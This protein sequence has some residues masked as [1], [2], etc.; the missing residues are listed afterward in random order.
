MR[1]SRTVLTALAGLAIVSLHRDLWADQ[2]IDPDFF[3]RI[4]DLR[5]SAKVSEA[6]SLVDAKI[7]ESPDNPSLLA[8]EADLYL[9]SKNYALAEELCHKALLKSSG[10]DWPIIILAKIQIQKNRPKL[11]LKLIDEVPAEKRGSE[12]HFL[13][14]RILVLQGEEIQAENEYELVLT[15]DPKNS[16]AYDRLFE[17]LQKKPD[18]SRLQK[19]A[20]QAASA[21]VPNAGLLAFAADQ[22]LLRGDFDQAEKFSRQ[23]LQLAPTYDWPLFTLVKVR[24][25]Q[26]RFPEALVTLD[27]IQKKDQTAGYHLL[28]AEAL[29]AQRKNAEADAEYSAAAALDPGNASIQ[30]SRAAN[31]RLYR[32]PSETLR[33]VDALLESGIRS[34]GLLSIQVELLMSAGETKKALKAARSAVA[35]N[36]KFEWAVLLEAKVFYQAGKPAESLQALGKISSPELAGE[37]H[38]L[39]AKILHDKRRF[40][41]ADREF[42]RALEA[43]FP[44]GIAPLGFFAGKSENLRSAGM[45]DKAIQT[46]DEGLRHYPDD[47]PL[48]LAKAELLVGTKRYPEAISA[49][50]AL[51]RAN[52]QLERASFLIAVAL[53]RMGRNA[54]ALNALFSVTNPSWEI[55]SLKG[56]IFNE[57]NRLPEAQGNYARAVSLAP[58]RP[59]LYVALAGVSRKQGNALEARKVIETAF[60]R[61]LTSAELYAM[62]ADFFFEDKKYDQAEAAAG[63]ALALNPDLGWAQLILSKA[64]TMSGHPLVAQKAIERLVSVSHPT[65]EGFMMQADALREMGFYSEADL[66]YAKAIRLRGKVPEFHE[67]RAWNGYLAGNYGLYE[68]EMLIA[69]KLDPKN[70]KYPATLANYYK[71]QRRY[72]NAE[73]MLSSGLDTC[74]SNGNCSSFYSV[75]QKDFYAYTGKS[76]YE[77][78]VGDWAWGAAFYD[79]FGTVRSDIEGIMSAML[80]QNA[81]IGAASADIPV[82]RTARNELGARLRVFPSGDS[83]VF[84]L[85]SRYDQ[86]FDPQD[87]F[88]EHKSVLARAEYEKTF[89]SDAGKAYTLAPYFQYRQFNGD[90]YSFANGPSTFFSYETYELGS[91]LLLPSIRNVLQADFEFGHTFGV[92]SQNRFQAGVSV[93]VSDASTLRFEAGATFSDD[94][95]SAEN[96]LRLQNRISYQT[97]L[98]EDVQIGPEVVLIHRTDRVAQGPMTS[99]SMVLPGVSANERLSDSLWLSQHATY[100]RPSALSEYQYMSLNPEIRY[101]MRKAFAREVHEHALP[102]EIPIEFT[103]GFNAD[104]FPEMA[105][106]ENRWRYEVYGKVSFFW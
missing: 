19:L 21:H 71:N 15:S 13:R 28:R 86:A 67:A 33:F 61:K 1:G 39:R 35:L 96:T 20:L 49:I 23:A 50:Q 18:P 32:P 44:G 34:A 22:E 55:F 41:E 89:V 85:S 53:H 106:G 16:Y 11:A 83:G 26:N 57:M 43:R 45:N 79:E 81:A 10:F 51:T 104:K 56:E 70:P 78:K 75:Y 90:D 84:T 87:N 27:L 100:M 46:L 7:A 80:Q 72:A 29:E 91:R 30:E 64:A 4:Q 58:D 36:A 8:L 60:E 73:A 105:T 68:S 102:Y 6:L 24:I 5:T 95:Y 42:Q 31:L 77:F 59:E 74:T 66:Q 12:F 62:Q 88:I 52:S 93:F 37:T 48:G 92:L 103:T 38:F 2:T 69:L 63:S 9:E 99:F 14:A 97:H 101:S 25:K 76:G 54:E 65:A 40:Q 47:L 94:T 98:N 3:R 82:Q 17:L